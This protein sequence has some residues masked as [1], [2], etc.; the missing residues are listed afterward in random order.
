[1]SL[2][3]N[4]AVVPENSAQLFDGAVDTL[5]SHHTVARDNPWVRKA[6]VLRPLLRCLASIV[7]CK[8]N[9]FRYNNEANSN[10]NIVERDEIP[11]RRG[12]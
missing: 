9:C 2:V 8:V 5:R 4:N 1:M 10:S 12:E 7:K 6:P 3:D 11:V